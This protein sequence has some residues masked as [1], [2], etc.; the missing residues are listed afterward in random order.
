MGNME[1]LGRIFN[2]VAAASGI[3]I[4]MRQGTGVTFLSFLDAGTQTVTLKQSIDG[5]SEVALTIVDKIH[6]APGVG[7]TW[8]EVT[9]AVA[10]NFNLTTDATNDQFTI[11][12]G[13]DQ[14]SDGY[15]C[16]EGTAGSG[17]LIAIIH[18]LVVQR[19]PQNLARN[20]V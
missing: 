16:V 20:V 8:T 7:G 1:G 14:L 13:A 2:V 15:N 17:I 12:V 9:Q 11:F 6:K 18:D 4:P 3:H 10:D 5:A 19:K